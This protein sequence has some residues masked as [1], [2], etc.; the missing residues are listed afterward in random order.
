[1]NLMFTVPGRPVSKARPRVGRHGTYTPEAT[2]AYAE[3]AGWLARSARPKDWPMDA[4]YGVDLM[5]YGAH[6]QADGD[7]IEKNILDGMNKVIYDDDRQVVEMHWVKRP[8]EPRV[9]VRVRVVESS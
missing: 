4:Q 8:G 5:I 3:Q 1:M 2:K 7:N 9:E 6:A